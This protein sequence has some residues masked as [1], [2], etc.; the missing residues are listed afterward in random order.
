MA[1]KSSKR[2]QKLYKMKGCSKHKNSKKRNCKHLGGAT[3]LAYTG[4]PVVLAPNPFLAY[5]GTGGSGLNTN[6]NGADPTMP[7][8]G[9]VD[10]GNSTIQTNHG[11]MQHGGT[12]GLCNATTPNM[13]TG[14]GCGRR[15]KGGCGPC[16]LALLGGKKKQKGGDATWAPQGLIGKPWTPNPAGWP[17]VDGVNGSRNYL[18]FNEYKVD[19]QTAMID[20][21]P[22][23]PFLGGRRKRKTRKQRGGT[24][25]NFIGQDLINLGRQVQFGIGSAYNGIT[26]Y[27]APVSP[28]PWRDQLNNANALKY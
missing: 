14:G 12:C 11:L 24:L 1:K 25:S 8:T 23:S 13:M 19:P 20:V 27:P 16:A 17:G 21:G 4:E 6:I 5:T 18:A 2:H 15:K 9:P 3:A 26:G 7:N 10:I 28:L 22:N